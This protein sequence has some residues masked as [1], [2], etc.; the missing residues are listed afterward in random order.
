MC[1]YHFLSERSNTSVS[2]LGLPETQEELEARQ[3]WD[4]DKPLSERLRVPRGEVF[5]PIPPQLL[6]KVCFAKNDLVV[7]IKCWAWFT[8]AEKKLQSM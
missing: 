1:I 7:E 4:A 2:I 8:L 6:R 5:D 3:H